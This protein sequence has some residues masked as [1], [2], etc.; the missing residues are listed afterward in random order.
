MSGNND[1]LPEPAG[2]CNLTSS[3][4]SEDSEIRK[5]HPKPE[6][7]EIDFQESKEPKDEEKHESLLSGKWLD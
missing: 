6:Q 2:V 4:E 3:D 5:T 7:I 1:L